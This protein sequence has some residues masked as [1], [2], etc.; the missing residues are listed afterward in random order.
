MN[1]RI[2][3]KRLKMANV[4]RIVQVNHE[5]RVVTVDRYVMFRGTRIVAPPGKPLKFRA[6]KEI[7]IL[8]AP[9]DHLG[10]LPPGTMVRASAEVWA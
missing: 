4:F 2:R 3:K 8:P 1:A 7:S 6:G 10:C 5:D 9:P